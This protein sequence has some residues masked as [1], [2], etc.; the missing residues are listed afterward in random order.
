MEPTGDRP[1]PIKK[2]VQ[3]NVQGPVGP[4]EGLM[5]Q[6]EGGR[7]RLVGQDP[8]AAPTLSPFPGR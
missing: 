5:R 3:E 6:R 2:L 4:R 1:L 7:A 8:P